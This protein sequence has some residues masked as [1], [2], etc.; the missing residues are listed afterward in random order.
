LRLTWITDKGCAGSAMSLQKGRSRRDYRKGS[1]LSRPSPLP[2]E[3]N[4]ERWITECSRPLT[5]RKDY[6]R[7]VGKG[8][9]RMGKSK[10]EKRLESALPNNE[11][12][13]DEYNRLLELFKTAPKERLALARKLI[14]RAAFLS[15]M[16]DE[17]ERDITLNGYEQ[18]YQ[19]GENQK[20]MK[21]SAAADLHVSYSKNLFAV[22]KQL[23]EM[24]DV[25]AAGGGDSFESF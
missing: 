22:M 11:A 25:K 15:V 20:G 7:G 21:K 14:S 18:E 23:N 9:K 13:R 24:L 19:N 10:V 5:A 16:I 3:V 6:S 17:F 12:V 4:G 1:G 2:C 8:V